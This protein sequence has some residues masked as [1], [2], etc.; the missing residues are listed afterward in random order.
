MSD[1]LRVLAEERARRLATTKQ[2]TPLSSKKKSPSHRQS[3]VT[4]ARNEMHLQYIN[5]NSNDVV[6]ILIK[7]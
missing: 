2:V 7:E 4:E 5:D 6:M 3:L 1:D